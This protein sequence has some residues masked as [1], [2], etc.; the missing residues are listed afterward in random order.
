METE[1]SSN[2]PAGAATSQQTAMKRRELS[3]TLV[4][5]AAALLV[6]QFVLVKNGLVAALLSAAAAAS[7]VGLNVRRLSSA[8]VFLTSLLCCLAL[9]EA[10]VPVFLHLAIVFLL[11]IFI[12]PYL[13]AWY[14]QAAVLIG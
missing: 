10:L 5:L 6:T 11:G 8:G 12:P 14:R 13:A 4:A 9:A 1:S 2:L 3:W 7:V